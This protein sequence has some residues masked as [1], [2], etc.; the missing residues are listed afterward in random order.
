MVR[1]DT[2]DFN[3]YVDGLIDPGVESHDLCDFGYS[4]SLASHPTCGLPGYDIEGG[5]GI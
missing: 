5:S 3:L 1:S 4:R 2:P